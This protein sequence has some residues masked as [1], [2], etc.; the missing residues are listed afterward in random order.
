[1]HAPL[2]APR[3]PLAQ[4]LA[5]LPAPL[6][7]TLLPP[8]LPAPLQPALLPPPSV[9]VSQGRACEGPFVNLL[10]DRVTSTGPWQLIGPRFCTERSGQFL[11]A[12]FYSIHQQVRWPAPVHTFR[13]D[14]DFF[15]EGQSGK[16]PVVP[17]HYP[18]RALPINFH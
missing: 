10:G 4:A 16:T 1:M 9:C 18:C 15:S 11:T 5:P 2:P 3:Q 12:F 13:V 6:Q 7:P 17:A 14:L 8:P